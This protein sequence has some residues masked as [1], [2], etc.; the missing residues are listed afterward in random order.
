MNENGITVDESD[1][2]Q[3]ARHERI[4]GVALPRLSLL[5]NDL[6][7]LVT[8]VFRPHI[9]YEHLNGADMMALT[10][11]TKQREHLRSVQTLLATRAHR[12]ALLIARTMFEGMAILLWA[13]RGKPERTD[14]WFWYGAILDWRQLRKKEEAG[15]PVDPQDWA[16]L[17]PHLDKHGPNYYQE[18]VRDRIREAERNGTTYELPD[19]P[20]RNKWNTADLA[21]MLTE[22]DGRDAYDLIYRQVSEWIHWG[23]RG[24]LR[25]MQPTDWGTAG[26]AEEDWRAA[27]LALQTGCQSLLQSLEVLDD[28]FSLRMAQDLVTLEET[29]LAI[30]AEAMDAGSP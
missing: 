13:F 3:L 1:E 9:P 19:D 2:Q 7:A 12:D 10:F 20:W 29:R 24:I 16:A 18:K 5:A 27:V 21:S 17:K 11:V 15:I 4:A 28:H 25:A 22:I 14:L 8:E 6:D 26:F 23:A 30:V